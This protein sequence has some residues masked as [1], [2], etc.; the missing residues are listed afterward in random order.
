ML[1]FVQRGTGAAQAAHI[2][3]YPDWLAGL[4][5]VR[6]VDTAEKAERFLHPSL[7]QLNDPS[8]MQGMDK[9][10]ALILRALEKK[11]PIV[12]YGDYDVDGVCAS[13]ILM[14]TIQEMG[15]RA[16]FYIPSRHGEGYGL[17]LAAIEAI[18]E[19]CRLLITV[20]C[21]VTNIGEVKAARDLGMTVI[22]TD[23]HQLGETLPPAHAVLNP[24][25][26]EY[27]FR[28]LC[29]AGVAFKLGQA[30]VGLPAMEKRL[31]L[32]ALATVADVVPLIDEN[33]VLVKEGLAR[34][35]GSSRPGLK[36][37]MRVAGVEKTVN[38]GQAGF[39]LAPRL[40]AGGRLEDAA[41]GVRLLTTLDQ[42]EAE[43]IAAHLNEANALRQ[44][45][46]REIVAKCLELMQGQVDFY[47][48]R[49][50]VILGDGWN[51]G[52]IGLAA[53]RLCEMYHYPAIV[54]SRQEGGLCV[55]SARSIPGV[56]IYGLLSK[57]R[58]LFVRFGG[59]EQAAGLT[60][61]WKLVPE[62]RRRLSL[63]IREECDP[64]CFVPVREYDLPL[65]LN[66]V[67]GELIEKLELFQPTGFGN[68]EPTFL[69][70]GAQVQ[71]MRPV[72][73]D[74]AHLKL[75]LLNGNAVLDGI[76]FSQGEEAKSGLTRVDCLF[77]PE[78]NVWNGVTSPQMQVKALKPTQGTVSLPE[79]T[80]FIRAY[81]QELAAASA[82]IVKISPGMERSGP[83][84][85]EG[86]LLRALEGVLGTLLIARSRE[87]ALEALALWPDLRLAEGEADDPRPFHTLLYLPKLDRLQDVWEKIV[88]LDGPAYPMERA[89]LEK[90]CKRAQILSPAPSGGLKAMVREL[91]V[92]DEPLRGLYRLLR[93]GGGRSLASLA[94]AS[95]LSQCQVLAGLCVFSQVGLAEFSAEPFSC[96]LLPPRKCS[97]SLSPLAALLRGMA[98]EL[99]A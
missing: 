39:R 18:S 51:S 28:R 61:E 78:W 94:R 62:L 21:G 35:A 30:L 57:C 69:V 13:A 58:D 52:V 93:D 84:L 41:Q 29:G 83:R 55:G 33:R 72:G 37:L 90:R 82:N 12:I 91:A 56:N 98:A 71:S 45:M 97:L 2:P 10:V 4:M 25:L 73:R 23:H 49:A 46:E 67:T 7:S 70:R 77:T 6:G 31:E 87:A 86:G 74:G 68:P 14:E 5:A 85:C 24:L 27:P 75:S 40:N 8:L 20:D 1:R 32:C 34:M 36:A 92:P 47:Q 22:V 48:H 44:G 15:G 88:L 80:E 19:K 81:L 95:G 26:G 11:D 43:G 63:Y 17:N 65:T 96:R 59:H 50:I 54:L 9:A 66:Q 64:E 53:S 60:M 42:E 99:P 38:A 3:G 76:A 89:A 16:E 79:E